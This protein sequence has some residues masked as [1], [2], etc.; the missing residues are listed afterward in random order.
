[1]ERGAFQGWLDGYV[2]AWKTYDEGAIGELFSENARYRYH[3]W[4]ERHAVVSGRA[5]IVFVRRP[6]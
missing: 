5:A 2:D 1:M 4:D 3:P 6:D